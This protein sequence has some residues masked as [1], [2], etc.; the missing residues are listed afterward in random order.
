[1]CIAELTGQL[2]GRFTNPA[3]AFA[4]VHLFHAHSLGD[5]MPLS[6]IDLIL[7][8]LLAGNVI[9]FG[10]KTQVLLY[11][12]S[13]KASTKIERAKEK[14]IEVVTWDQFAATYRIR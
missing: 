9:A 12:R 4:A 6:N 11:S 3:K 7:V 13:G 10:S 1:M 14:G 2:A 8:L 5:A